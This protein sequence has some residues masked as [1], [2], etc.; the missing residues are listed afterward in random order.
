LIPAHPEHNMFLEAKKLRTFSVD[1]YLLDIFKDSFFS[2]FS[3]II[4]K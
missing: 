2:G 4:I 3:A 1:V